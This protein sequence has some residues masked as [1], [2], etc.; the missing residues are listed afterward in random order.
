VKVQAGSVADIQKLR[1]GTILVKTKD[2]KQAGALL[3]LRK[4]GDTSIKVDAHRSLNYSKGVVKCKDLMSS[5]SEEI[6]REL[7]SQG[8]VACRNISVRSQAGECR[9]SSTFILAFHT[10]TVP[11]HI[12]C[13]FSSS[14]CCCLHSQPSQVFQLSKIWTCSKQL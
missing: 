3:C 10:T 8:V 13:R 1:N 14:T 6:V 12:R 4:V 7:W 11:K 9:D 5:S 2:E